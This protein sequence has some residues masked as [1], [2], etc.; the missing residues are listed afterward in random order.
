[1]ADHP[2]SSS[3]E[4]HSILGLGAVCKAYKSFVSKCYPDKNSS[5]RKAEIEDKQIDEAYKAFNDRNHDE[6]GEGIRGGDPISPRGGFKR[7]SVDNYISSQ[8]SSLSSPSVSR[9]G[10]RRNRESTPTGAA[11]LLRNASRRSSVDATTF[12]GSLSRSAS[13]RSSTPIMYSNSNGLIKLPA[14]EM[15]LECTLEELCYGCIKKINI[16]RD[17]VTNDGQI[18]QEEEVLTIKV[19]PGWRTGTIITFEGMGNETPGTLPAD[20][21]FVIVEKW[22]PLFKREGDD[23]ELALEIPL[24]QALTG[25]T[26]SIP[27]VGGEKM[28]LTMDD[29]LY[30]GYEKII[31]GQGMPKPKEQGKRGNL[32]VKFLIEFPVELTEE[33]RSEVFSILQSSC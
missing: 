18:V 29:I 8:H 9:S 17:V 27:L 20:I 24:V 13:R 33:Q 19:K 10:S 5:L 1:M 4:F 3:Q 16:I 11:N 26:V 25:C 6:N 28:S 23:L 31:A 12:N 14:I 7:R 21:T 2:R 32:V 15:K 30:P 22:H